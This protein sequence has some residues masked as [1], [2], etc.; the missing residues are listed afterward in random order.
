MWDEL[1][2]QLGAEF[3]YRPGHWFCVAH[4]LVIRADGYPFSE[5]HGGSGRRVVLA[6]AHG[7]NATLFARSG[8]RETPYAHK[9]HVHESSSERCKI[10]VDGW[11]NLR[12]PVSVDADELNEGTYS[13]EEPTSTTLKAE[14]E[15]AVR[16]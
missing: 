15:R 8:S 12:I 14:M 11:V 10:D 13:C 3:L 5:K 16:P 7:P 1:R 9:A 6:T 4:E 2:R